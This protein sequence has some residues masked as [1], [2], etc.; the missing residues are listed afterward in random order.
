MAVNIACPHCQAM[1]EQDVA[2]GTVARLTCP[3]C[4]KPYEVRR[5]RAKGITS[6]QIAVSQISGYDMAIRGATAERDDD[7]IEFWGMLIPQ[8]NEGDEVA[9]TYP[10]DRH[11]VVGKAGAV[12]NLNV[13]RS[14]PMPRQTEKLGC[15][16]K[17]A[18][19]AVAIGAAGWLLS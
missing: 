10:V 3:S 18:M 8:V 15:G 11:G 9:V 7:L 5:I 19:I 2:A 6:R 14:W 17:A 16:S 1:G 13:A 4:S 12:T